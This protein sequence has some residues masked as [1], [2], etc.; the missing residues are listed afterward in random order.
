[1]YKKI[2]HLNELIPKKKYWLVFR[3][4]PSKTKIVEYNIE[5]KHFSNPDYD[6]FGPLERSH[7]RKENKK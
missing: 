3:E 5:D 6:V 2:K 1:M 4:N 7:L